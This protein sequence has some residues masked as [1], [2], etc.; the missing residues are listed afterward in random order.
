MLSPLENP[1]AEIVTLTTSFADSSDKDRPADGI[2]LTERIKTLAAPYLR[3][4]D[5]ELFDLQI[6][7]NQVRIFIDKESGVTLEHC[8][9]LSRLL[10]P[11]LDVDETMSR[12]YALEISSPGLNRPL[13]HAADFLR[14]V[15]KKI[16]VKTYEK[17]EKQKV[18]IGCLNDFREDAV[19]MTTDEGDTL[20]IPFDQVAKACLEPE[21]AL[22]QKKRG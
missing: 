6:S 17:I 12:A 8:S 22:E 14:Y 4:L 9:K 3:S 10:G 15:G 11:A 18:F 1:I 16:K 19:F 5:L 2:S 7:G 20:R 13:R 21:F